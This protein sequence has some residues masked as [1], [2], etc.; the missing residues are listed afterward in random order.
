MLNL[1]LIVFLISFLLALWSVISENSGK[2]WQETASK[3]R[4]E[5]IKGTI[6]IEKGRE[7]KHYSSYS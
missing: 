2:Q 6:M 1:V 5:R 3:Y 4:Q 7:P